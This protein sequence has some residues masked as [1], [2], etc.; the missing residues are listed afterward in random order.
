MARVTLSQAGEDVIVGGADV[1]VIGTSAGGEVITV[2]SGNIRL[3]PSFNQGGDTIVLPGDASDYTAYRAGGEVIFT[4]LD[5]T[6]TLRI[7]VGGNGTEIQFDGGDSRTLVFNSTTG[8][9]T[10]EGQ[11]LGTSSTSP[12]PLTPSGPAPLVNYDVTGSA[13]SVAEGDTGTR[14]L[15]FTITLDR[16]V[17]AADGPVTL[18]YQT[19]NGTAD[20]ATD[21]VAAAGTVTFAVGQQVATVTVVVNSDTTPE[22]NETLNL[23]LTG[24]KLRNGPETLVGTITNDDVAV[25]LTGSADNFTG[26]VN[27]DSFFAA[28]TGLGA[29]DKISDGSTTD[30]DTFSLAVDATTA[31]RNFGGFALTNIENVE[32]TNDSGAPVTLD[33]S[34]STGIKSV[35]SVNSSD[36]VVFDQLTSNATVIVDN[37]TGAN[38]NVEAIYQA[39]V[40]AG[41][42]T[43]VNVVINDTTANRVILGTV[44][45]GNTGIETVNLQ[46]TGTSTINRL[47][48]QLTTLNISGGGDVTLAEPLVNSVRVVD[49]STAGRVTVDFT[50]NDA[51]GTGV[52]FTG[53]NGGDI[54][55]S[56]LAAD[57]VSTG[58]GDDTV[59]DEGGN[60]VINTGGGSDTIN[61]LGAGDVTIN[62][63]SEADTV[64]FAAGTFNGTDKVAL[65]DGSDTLVVSQSTVEADYTNVSSAETLTV[66]LNANTNLGSN[67]LGSLAQAA[68]ISTVNLNVN[69]VGGGSDTLT[70]TDYTVGLTVNL[71][72]AVGSDTVL[73]GSGADVINTSSFD[74]SDNLQGNLGLDTINVTD[75]STFVVGGQFGGIETI[76]YASDGDGEDQVLLVTDANAPSAG[77]VLT[78]N[79]GSLAAT[80]DFTF[81]SQGVAAYSVNVTTGAGNDQVYTDNGVADVISTGAGQDYL[82]IAGG[83]TA[84]TGADIDNV[85]VFN[86]NNTVNAGDGND[87]IGLAGTGNSTLNG[88]AGDDVF[89]IYNPANLTSGDTISGGAGNDQID[90]STG[91]YTDV[92]FTNVTGV[93]T[94]RGFNGPVNV[95]LGLEAQDGG[96]GI[97]TVILQDGGADTLNASAYTFGLTVNS[98]GGNDVIT[99]GSGDDIINLAGAGSVTVDTGAGN[100]RIRV[101]GTTSLDA[102]DKIAGGLGTDVIELDNTTG[103]VVGTVDL[104]NVTGI[105]SFRILA[106]GNRTAGVD[107]DNNVL[108]F[109][110]S[111]GDV[112]TSVTPVNIDASALTDGDDSLTVVI[113]STVTDSDFSFNITGSATTTTV[114]KQNVGINN[115]INFTGGTGVDILRIA[116]SDAGS[117][118]I[119]NG[120]AGND[121]IIQT[122]ASALTD[123]GF[124]GLSSVEILGSATTINAVLGSRASAAGI[125]RINGT[126]GNDVVTVG[127]GFTTAL[128]VNLGGGN[129]NISALASPAALTFAANAADFTNADVLIGGTGTGDVAAIT[130]GGTADLTTVTKVETININNVIT[131]GAE[132]T[133]VNLDQ[134]AAEVD[135]SVLTVNVNGSE[136]GDSVTLNGGTVTENITYNGGAGVD[137]VTTGSGADIVNGN[138]GADVIVVGLGNDTVNG[139]AGDD[140]VR[141]QGGDDIING[142]DGNDSLY[143]DIIF[144]DVGNLAAYNAAGGGA[145][146]INGGIGD[147]L[148]VG[149]LGK[150]TLTGGAGADVFRYFSVEDSR[151]I[152]SA[153]APVDARDV[154][155]D[156]VAGVDK[157]DLT[158]LAAAAGQTIRFN[159][160]FGTYAEAQAAV[161]STAGDGFLDVAFVRNLGGQSVLFVDVDNNG[162]L[163]GNDLQIIMTNVTGTLTAP[164]VN[165]PHLVTGPEMAD[166]SFAGAGQFG[167]ALEDHFGAVRY[168]DMFQSMHIA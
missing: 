153:G 37:V 30:N 97:R 28:N 64:N 136:A 149:G 72:G 26:S 141:G 34:S 69:G 40:T 167:L 86:G 55:R 2:V 46:V 32:V 152:Q 111:V 119:F 139:G 129:D 57:T 162:Q 76:N 133:V 157:I 44:G 33:L 23:L 123:D 52:T 91:T 19:Q 137:I 48:T 3:D 20:S 104:A 74:G 60:D 15:V 29:G 36:T 61:L 79:A 113:A 42:N 102:T 12:T 166:G 27:S 6:V 67:G 4:S 124:I 101:S 56:G 45:A 160:D 82:Q 168:A 10:L 146:T 108:T 115:N 87:F 49:A 68:G 106:S 117:T 94:L 84:N 95:T 131:A 62:A 155:T 83:D 5:G 121:Q 143:G 75:G 54:V 70:A 38:A 53:S 112:V 65:G 125:V 159:G 80:E 135:G 90:V 114:D 89:A 130:A 66:A 118:V 165:N 93:E 120:G 128:L 35:A 107:T 164:D 163:D 147:D 18:N 122:G 71:G 161:G 24:A 39:A 13:A 58:L 78:V 25:S 156:F 51:A 21:Y 8:Q 77:N 138:G 127:A 144:A 31:N 1:Q 134:T 154:I 142:D 151:F 96:N 7:P 88:E 73:L 126:A 85:F 105:D 9:A 100:D 145:D 158:Q 110:S 109:S 103:A 59:T 92:Q 150:D 41:A 132:N 16:A 17:T 50:N 140:V 14:Q 47:A 63:G 81:L 22:A 11:A 99:T 43:A 116:G 98:A 148:I